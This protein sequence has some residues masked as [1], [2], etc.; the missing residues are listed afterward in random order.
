MHGRKEFECGLSRAYIK[1]ARRRQ[2][3]ERRRVSNSFGSKSRRRSADSLVCRIAGCELARG[4]SA[5]RAWEVWVRNRLAVGDMADMAACA[6]LRNCW[7][8]GKN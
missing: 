7:L 3:V 1:A 8:G 2:K 4:P 6:H 5:G